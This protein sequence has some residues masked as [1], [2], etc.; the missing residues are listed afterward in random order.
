MLNTWVFSLASLA[1][2]FGSLT[3]RRSWRRCARLLPL[4]A[5]SL[6]ACDELIGLDDLDKADCVGECSAITSGRSSG[7]NANA[8]SVAVAGGVSA[9]G[10][11]GLGGVGG[12]GGKAGSSTSA[13]NGGVAPSGGTASHQAGEAG[14]SGSLGS[15]GDGGAAAVE[16]S[17]GR[18]ATAST[19]QSGN[20]IKSGN[21]GNSATRWSASSSTLPQWWR[22]DL[23]AERSLLEF[24]V[25]WEHDDRKYSYRIE[26]SN[27]DKVFTTS[28]DAAATGSPQVGEFPAGTRARYVRVTVVATSPGGWASFYE[29]SLTGY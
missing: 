20:L 2:V 8:G 26:T 5:L 4:L 24:S 15:S 11:G 25:E 23:G 22:V 17:Q 10:L 19:E 3:A 13:G 6:A 7:G 21:D 12:V 28:V 9:G 27:D 1:S 29:L 16:L 18:S 14:S